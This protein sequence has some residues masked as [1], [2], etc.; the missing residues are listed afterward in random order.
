MLFKHRWRR[1]R[2]CPGT[3][4]RNGQSRGDADQPP[5]AGG[6]VVCLLAFLQLLVPGRGLALART[7]NTSEILRS[8]IRACQNGTVPAC[9]DAGASL[10]ESD[11]SRAAQLYDR[12]CRAD[13]FD[14]CFNLAELYRAR[15]GRLRLDLY[16]R[17][18]AG[19]A[20]RACTN[21]GRLAWSDEPDRARR[22]WQAGC[23]GGQAVSCLQMGMTLTD[24]EDARDYL[25][26]ACDAE[27][28]YGCFEAGRR[29]MELGQTEEALV[30]FQ[31]GCNLGHEGACAEESRLA[32]NYSVVIYGAPIVAVILI[33]ALL[34][35]RRKKPPHRCK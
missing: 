22:L 13:H 15:F 31:R 23:Q 5:G 32:S 2:V 12:A 20:L 35:T 17:A 21:G 19:G 25:Q 26:L 8:Q 30:A 33:A 24:P 11:P 3:S 27:V 9:F 29:L 4:I 16:Q 34:W 28:S 14:A 1:Q 7:P 6:T 18:C 10:Q